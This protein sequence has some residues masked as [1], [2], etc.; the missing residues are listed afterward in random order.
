MESARR[1]IALAG[2][3]PF[4]TVPF[5]TETT[6][7]SRWAREPFRLFF[8]LGVL[9]SWVGIGHWLFYVTGVTG[10]YSCLAHGLVQVQAFLPAFS[11]GAVYAAQG[12]LKQAVLFLE[13]AVEFEAIPQAF[14][15]LGGCCYEMG[16]VTAAI[17]SLEQAVRLD[18]AFED[19]YHLLGLAFLDRRSEASKTK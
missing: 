1:S 19:A 18:P 3:T 16:K 12:R 7:K 8:P 17:R 5:M 14:Y 2:G 15:L 9:I 10:A 11:L 4:E 13:R 6:A